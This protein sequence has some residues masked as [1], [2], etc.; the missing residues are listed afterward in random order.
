MF[1]VSRPV[2]LSATVYRELKTA[3]GKAK[4]QQPEKLKINWNFF[5]T[6]PSLKKISGQTNVYREATRETLGK[7]LA[8]Q[9]CRRSSKQIG[10][11]GGPHRLARHFA[12]V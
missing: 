7:C 2:R 6:H 9:R 12:N 5:G 10:F 1:T 3:L 4:M 8:K 11:F